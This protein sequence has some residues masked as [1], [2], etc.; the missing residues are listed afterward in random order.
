MSTEGITLNYDENGNVISAN[1]YAYT[2]S[3][4]AGYAFVVLFGLTT[5]AHVVMM[6]PMKAGFFI[7]LI[8]GGLME[9]GGYY[10][11]AW[12]H[13]DP[14]SFGAWALQAFLIICAP[15]LISATVYMSLGRLIRAL[16]GRQNSVISPRAM[17][18]LFVTVDIIAFVSQL[19]GIGLQAARSESA[20]RIGKRIVLAGLIFQLVLFAFFIFAIFIFHRRNSKNPTPLS[21]ESWLPNWKLNIYALYLSSVCI[22]LRNFVR[23]IEY[24][25]GGKGQIIKNEVYV[26]VFDAAL[27]WAA[28]TVFVFVHP[29]KL[30]KVA[31]RAA[32]AGGGNAGFNKVVDGHLAMSNLA[33]REPGKRV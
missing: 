7:P 19:A 14:Q 33:K 1:Y 4:A 26:Y 32:G 31:N 24:A 13:R 30:P 11:R 2:P 17:T 3:A 9:A 25:Q 5:L 8:I 22:L 16:D 28:M 21:L 15:P 12:A 23:V 20:N 29:G 6:F 27:M 18:P 10:G